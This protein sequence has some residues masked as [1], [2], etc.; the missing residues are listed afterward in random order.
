MNRTFEEH[1]DN[2]SIASGLSAAHTAAPFPTSDR[3]VRGASFHHSH[4]FLTDEY[5]AK[6][7]C[8]FHQNASPIRLTPGSM[9]VQGSFA[10]S[11]AYALQF[12]PSTS[13]SSLPFHQCFLGVNLE[14]QM[15]L[16]IDDDPNVTSSYKHRFVIIGKAHDY[17][18]VLNAMY[19]T[20]FALLLWLSYYVK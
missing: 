15:R 12:E 16:T 6:P 2:I 19:S 3:P 5:M 9:E 14:P 17:F 4:S 20:S 11:T 7:G 10:V 18:D 13:A 8:L 1:D